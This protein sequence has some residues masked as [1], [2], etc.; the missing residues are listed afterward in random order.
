[1]RRD[2]LCALPYRLEQAIGEFPADHRGNLQKPLGRPRQAVDPRHDDVVDRVWNPGGRLPTSV[3]AGMQRELFEEK[4][5]AVALVDDCRGHRLGPLLVA[6]DGANDAETVF[7]RQGR[8]SDGR[9]RACPATA[10]DTPG[11]RSQSP[12]LVPW[13][14]P[15]PTR[16]G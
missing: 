10:D 14:D 7:A 6:Q 11:G 1:M 2:R 16:R 8:H 9:N 3:L 13:E 15:R 12:G 4:R 5:I